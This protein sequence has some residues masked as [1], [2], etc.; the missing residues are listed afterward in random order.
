M[1]MTINK[2]MDNPTVIYLQSGILPAY[3]NQHIE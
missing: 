2:V 3:G 1:Q